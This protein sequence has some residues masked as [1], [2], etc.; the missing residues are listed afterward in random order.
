MLG[1]IPVLR[2]TGYLVGGEETDELNRTLFQILSMDKPR[3]IIDCSQVEN[4]T[5]IVLRG[6]TEMRTHFAARGGRLVM[7]GVDKKITD[8]V[9]IA[10]LSLAAEIFV[11]VEAAVAELVADRN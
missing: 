11:N 7:A 8:L 5:S 3:A 10:K 1:E 9:V 6:L 4:I 2:P